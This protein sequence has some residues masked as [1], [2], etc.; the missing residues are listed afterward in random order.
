MEN[1]EGILA[2]LYASTG[3][4]NK[5]FQTMSEG[6]SFQFARLK[7]QMKSVLAVIGGAA[8]PTII[9]LAEILAKVFDQFPRYREYVA[10]VARWFE[11]IAKT[12]KR[13]LGPA[14]D[15]PVWLGGACV[16]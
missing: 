5:A 15:P 1:F 8:L 6:A 4:T 7:E 3:E 2:D 11:H 12:I 16:C 13:D 9:E 14:F 10:R